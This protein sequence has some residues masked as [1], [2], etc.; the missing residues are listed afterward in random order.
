MVIQGETVAKADSNTPVVRGRAITAED[1]M[2]A[3]KPGNK[4]KCAILFGVML[5]SCFSLVPAIV[6]YLILTENGGMD[7]PCDVP[8]P[9]WLALSAIIV[10]ATLVAQ[11]LVS[12]LTIA[13]GTEED[14]KMKK[15]PIAACL[16]CLTVFPLS[17]FAFY[18]YIKGNYW[19][20]GTHAY[21]AT[22][23]NITELALN[24]SIVNI[25]E[26]GSLDKGVGCQPGILQGSRV[27][28]IVSY[29][30]PGAILVLVCLCACCCFCCMAA[31]KST[32]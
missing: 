16:E 18:W 24:S 7:T 27:F 2:G 17:I 10:L 15:P 22:V 32:A 26:D 8:I 9:W 13:C 4:T 23:T 5:C 21:N 30:A 3:L 11:L 31:R 20:W 12:C 6:Q 29:A 14:G 19:A 1:A 25:M 28:L